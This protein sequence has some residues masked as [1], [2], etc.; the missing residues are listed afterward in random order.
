[1]QS[2][3]AKLRKDTAAVIIQ[4]P[5]FFGIIED[6]NNVAE[7]VHKNKSLLII[8]CDPISLALFKSPGEMGADIVVGDGQCLGNSLSFGGPYLGFF[9]T[10]KELMRKMPGRVVGETVD[11]N[12]RRGFV[13]TLQTREQHIEEEKKAT[14]EVCSNQA[15]N[16]LN[17]TIYLSTM[18]KEGLKRVALLCTQKAHYTYEQLIKSG[19]FL[20]VFNA[21]FFK[22]FAVKYKDDVK[23]LNK[24]AAG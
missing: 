7:I 22:E 16:A 4:T 24:K 10:T 15:L 18:G 11:K 14:S 8:S 6:L 5:N 3:K 17:A 12:G 2:W 13:L 9:A 19:N 21:P 1:M 23:E 20:A